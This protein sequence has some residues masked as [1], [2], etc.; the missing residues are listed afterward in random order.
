VGILWLKTELLHPVDNGL[1]NP[2]LTHAEKAQPLHPLPTLDNVSAAE[3][4]QELRITA[5]KSS[6]CS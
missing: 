1:Q 6:S 3:E 5:T 4:A 2:H